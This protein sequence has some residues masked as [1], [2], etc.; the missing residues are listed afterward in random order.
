M[1]HL[2][3]CD[4]TKLQKSLIFFTVSCRSLNHV[5]KCEDQDQ[6]DD[7]TTHCT[8]QLAQFGAVKT[9]ELEEGGTERS[10]TL[11]NK[12]RYVHKVARF[13]LIGTTHSLTHLIARSLTQSLNHLLAH[14]LTHSLTTHP[15]T[16]SLSLSLSLRLH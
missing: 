3:V 13:Y 12:R 8:A 6:L 10:V 14:S 2:W 16:L 11:E 15:P 9:V 1:K 7:L 5:L 4:F